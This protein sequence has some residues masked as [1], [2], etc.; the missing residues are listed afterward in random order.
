MS[1]ILSTGLQPFY[2]M[3]KSLAKSRP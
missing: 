3:L 2:R 1:L